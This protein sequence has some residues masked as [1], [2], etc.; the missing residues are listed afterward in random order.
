[1]PGNNTTNAKSILKTSS[2]VLTQL[3]E[4]CQYTIFAELYDTG[5]LG[6]VFQ[7]SY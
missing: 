5:F 2:V 6:S 4:I 7:I 3:L 1:M